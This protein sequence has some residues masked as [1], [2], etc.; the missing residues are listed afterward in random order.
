MTIALGVFACIGGLF[1]LSAV[2]PRLYLMWKVRRFVSVSS[3]VSFEKGRIVL[4]LPK[5]TLSENIFARAVPL[6]PAAHHT[7]AFD[8]FM[9]HADAQWTHTLWN[10][11]G[12]LYVEQW[13]DDYGSAPGLAEGIYIGRSLLTAR[14]LRKGEVRK[15]QDGDIIVQLRTYL[16]PDRG[17]HY[18]ELIKPEARSGQVIAFAA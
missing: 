5:V 7:V 18:V 1:V 4:S 16:V 3:P 14:K 6:S 12:E 13:T 9:D 11:G 8:Y 10:R 15:L 17:E 2:F